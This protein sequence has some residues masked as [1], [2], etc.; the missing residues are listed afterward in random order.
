MKFIQQL[1]ECSNNRRRGVYFYTGPPKYWQQQL[2]L[3]E[4]DI[5]DYLDQYVTAVWG[6]VGVN[7]FFQQNIK[8]GNY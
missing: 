5:F 8:K 6:G 4:N 3:G 1:Q 7:W 2:G